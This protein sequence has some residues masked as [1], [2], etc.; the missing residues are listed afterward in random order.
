[1]KQYVGPERGTS[2]CVVDECAHVVFEGEA[3]SDPG[4]TAGPSWDLPKADTPCM[5]CA[6]GTYRAS[7]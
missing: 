3:K 4:F 6:R 7:R 2:V 5:E 1:M